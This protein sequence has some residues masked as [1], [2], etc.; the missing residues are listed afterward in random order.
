[1]RLTSAW[2]W[3]AVEGT[4]RKNALF[5]APILRPHPEFTVEVEGDEVS[6]LRH[7]P[8]S[9][10]ERNYRKKHGV[11]GLLDRMQEVELP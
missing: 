4:P 2:E 1:M 5:L 7:V 11:D 10:A 9:D 3:P 6:F 8:I